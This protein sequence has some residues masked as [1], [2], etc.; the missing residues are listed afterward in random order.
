MPETFRY[1]SAIHRRH[2]AIA[3]GVR[4]HRPNAEKKHGKS[5]VGMKKSVTF[6]TVILKTI[7]LP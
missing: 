2:A 5:F 1:L 3:R 4:A 6:A 7:F